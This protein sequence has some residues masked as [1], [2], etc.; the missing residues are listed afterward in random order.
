MWLEGYNYYDCYLGL[1]IILP[2]LVVLEIFLSMC[3]GVVPSSAQ[4]TCEVPG[5]EPSPPICKASTQSLELSLWHL[6]TSGLRR[7]LPSSAQEVGRQEG[8]HL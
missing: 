2:L 1:V 7:L 5:I 6:I 8:G 4:T 3:S